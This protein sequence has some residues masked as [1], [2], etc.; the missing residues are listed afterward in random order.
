MHMLLYIPEVV[1]GTLYPEQYFLGYLGM[2]FFNLRV[3]L[4][5]RFNRL[6]A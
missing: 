3:T 2:Y 6:K 5:I 4:L 1:E